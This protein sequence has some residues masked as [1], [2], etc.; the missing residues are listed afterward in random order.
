MPEGPGKGRKETPAHVPGDLADPSRTQA[1]EKQR[2][3]EKMEK[4]Q[5]ESLKTIQDRL[6]QARQKELESIKKQS[7]L[8]DKLKSQELEIARQVQ[9]EKN[10]IHK[11]VT[12]LFPPI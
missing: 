7:E 11:I 4:E 6:D 3:A 2:M 5:S 12:F 8:E 10:K 9:E 1:Q